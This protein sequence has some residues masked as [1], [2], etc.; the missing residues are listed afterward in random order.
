[1]YNRITHSIALISSPR[2]PSSEFAGSICIRVAVPVALRIPRWHCCHLGCR[3]AFLAET[4]LAT[5]AAAFCACGSGDLAAWR[6]GSK[7][8]WRQN[9]GGVTSSFK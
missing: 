4:Q 9:K 7:H 2:A 5:G 8:G 3:A 1:M 6:Q